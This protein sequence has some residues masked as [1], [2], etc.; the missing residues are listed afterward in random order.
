MDVVRSRMVSS[1]W[2]VE[3]GT[4]YFWAMKCCDLS[5]VCRL[6]HT[7]VGMFF[8]KS[9]VVRC[10]TTVLPTF[11]PENKG[12]LDIF[13]PKCVQG[14]GKC[15]QAE[16]PFACWRIQSPT[17]RWSHVEAESIRQ[18]YWGHAALRSIALMASQSHNE[19]AN[20][21]WTVDCNRSE[22]MNAAT[23]QVERQMI[24]RKWLWASHR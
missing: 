15:V 5:S 18:T 1:S 23:A 11:A 20:A 17:T 14:G 2:W 3:E 12:N 24:G 9:Y 21:T 8:P 13:R 4:I 7:T 6:A 10:H 16:N 22:S 19:R